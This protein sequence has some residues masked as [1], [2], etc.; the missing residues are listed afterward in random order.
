MMVPLVVDGKD[1]SIALST[2]LQLR[3][4][5]G[6]LGIAA[7]STILHNYLKDRLSGALD[8][9]QVRLLLH[10][11]DVIGTLPPDIQNLA[12]EAYSVAYSAQMKLAG[13]FSAAQLV[14]VAMIW[15]R[16]NVRYV[17]R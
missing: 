2:G 1:Q 6:V 5:G 7:A 15:K 9:E 8:P 12:R 3:M 13:A 11:G 17:K 16:T 14:A 4:L 10:S